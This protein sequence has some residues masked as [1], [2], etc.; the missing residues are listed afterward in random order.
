MA[1]KCRTSIPT[2]STGAMLLAAVL[3]AGCSQAAGTRFLGRF[4]SDP[5][6][7]IERRFGGVADET[8]DHAKLNALTRR[9]AAVVPQ[10]EVPCR[11]VLLDSESRAALSLSDGRIY[12]TR[13]LYRE[14]NE[15]MLAAV[16]AHEVAHVA[17]GD[18]ESAAADPHGKLAKEMRADRCA[19]EYLY[20]AGFSS[21]GLIETLRL[22]SADQ[23]AGWAEARL[24]AIGEQGEIGRHRRRNAV[25]AL[26]AAGWRLD[27]DAGD[28]RCPPRGR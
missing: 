19:C 27:A 24:R 5:G 8:A 10:L 20:A 23:P 6:S 21:D 28:T 26:S 11:C 18:G 9:I 14:L 1:W 2:C 16:L 13:G 3:A 22:L 7:Q 4:T 15:P 25:G 12:L 17:A